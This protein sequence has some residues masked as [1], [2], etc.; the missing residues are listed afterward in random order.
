[1]IVV[2]E[3]SRIGRSRSQAAS[4]TAGP[5]ARRPACSS[6]EVTSTMALFTMIPVIP[7]SPTTVNMLAGNPH[8]QCP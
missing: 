6:I 1:M 4:T 5:S 2:S 8:A 7:I 3:V